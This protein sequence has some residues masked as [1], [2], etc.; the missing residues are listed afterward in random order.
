MSRPM[1]SARW[2]TRS[3][4]RLSALFDLPSGAVIVWTLAACAVLFAMTLGA[5]NTSRDRE[6]LGAEPTKG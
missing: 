1:A 5:S 4:W 3:G 2:A 6:P